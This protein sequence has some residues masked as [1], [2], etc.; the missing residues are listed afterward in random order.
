[1]RQPRC[2]L[3]L[4][5]FITCGASATLSAILEPAAPRANAASTDLFMPKYVKGSSTNKEGSSTNK[6]IELFNGTGAAI[7]LDDTYATQI[8]AN[9]SAMA[10]ATIPL[11]GTVPASA[12]FVL[13]REG[14]APELVGRADQLTGNFLF[15]RTIKI[16]SVLKTFPGTRW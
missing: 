5:S 3:I 14:S 2:L 12:T 10:T 7:V 4:V 1:M 13:A 11:S 8:F 6:A 16:Q 15:R 9:G